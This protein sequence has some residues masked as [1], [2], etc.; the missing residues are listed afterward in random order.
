MRHLTLAEYKTTEQVELTADERDAL[1]DV[2]PSIGITPSRHSE[3]HYDLTPSSLVG[4]VDLTTLAIEIRPKLPFERLLFLIS[5]SLGRQGWR[6][7]PFDLERADSLVEAI[8]PGFV[9]QLRRALRRGVLQG[10][11]T[12]EDA[13]ATVRGR[14]RIDDQ[15]RRHFGRLPP[16]E[17]RY[18][19]FTEDIEENRLLKAAI[20]R[21]KR[22]RIRSDAVRR[23][24]RAFDLTLAGVQAVEYDPR[25]LPEI[26]WTRL[27]ERYR[28]AVELAKLILRATSFE[29]RH[30]NVHASAFLVDMNQ[31]FEDFVVVALRDELRASDRQLPQGARGRTIR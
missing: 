9:S 16:V 17:V 13:L 14:I 22:L 27:N 31:V 12:E 25:R 23:S 30:G 5:Y 4:V 24:L 26:S 2:A 3:G 1:R 28:P 6:D 20:E 18:D 19:E 7:V 29:S 15:L 11:R 21:L 10:Y 8:V